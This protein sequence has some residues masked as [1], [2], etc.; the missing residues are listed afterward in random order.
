MTSDGTPIFSTTRLNALKG[1]IALALLHRGSG[2]PRWENLLARAGHRN[3][4]QIRMDP[5]LPLSV[6]ERV[7]GGAD[8]ER[9][10]CDETVWLPQRP[11]CPENGAP[12]CPDCGGTGDLRDAVG[13]FIDTRLMRR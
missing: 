6:F 1:A 9:I 4:V 12:A 7:L 3:L 8:Q 5:D 2:H 13:S 11:D 10:V